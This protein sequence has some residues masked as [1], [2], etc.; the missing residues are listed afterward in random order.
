MEWKGLVVK[1][2]LIVHSSTENGPERKPGTMQGR[3]KSRCLYHKRW[4]EYKYGQHRCEPSTGAQQSLPA[5]KRGG[6]VGDGWKRRQTDSWLGTSDIFGR[7][8]CSDFSI[9]C[10]KAENKW[11]AQWGTEVW[12]HGGQTC[13]GC[14][15]KCGMETASWLISQAAWAGWGL[16]EDNRLKSDLETWCSERLSHLGTGITDANWNRLHQPNMEKSLEMNFKGSFKM[17]LQHVLNSSNLQ[18]YGDVKLNQWFLW[19]GR[20]MI[21]WGKKRQCTSLKQT[22]R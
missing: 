7:G 11:D 8:F 18:L 14:N 4:E 16:L 10:F 6:K 9:T 19:H 1:T 22:P 2:D 12:I 15:T 3:T 21:I 13:P 5:L 20:N 17:H